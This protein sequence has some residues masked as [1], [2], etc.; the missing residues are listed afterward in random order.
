MSRANP[1]PG[2]LV[3]RR[4][5]DDPGL[6]RTVLQTLSAGRNGIDAPLRARRLVEIRLGAD[7]RNGISDASYRRA[8]AALKDAGRAAEA[9]ALETIA[10]TGAE[11]HATR[12]EWQDRYAHRPRTETEIRAM[13]WMSSGRVKIKDYEGVTGA[14]GALYHAAALMTD[15]GAVPAVVM[16]SRAGFADVVDGFAAGPAMR[17]WLQDRAL[18]IT[19]P[20]ASWATG[21]ACRAIWE[22][23]ILAWLLQNGGGSGE[24]WRPRVFTTY[25]RSEIFLAWRAVSQNAPGGGDSRLAEAELG[26]RLLRAPGWAVSEIGWPH[27]QNTVAYLRRLVVTPVTTTMAQLAA[28]QLVGQDRAALRP[29]AKPTAYRPSLAPGEVPRATAIPCVLEPPPPTALAPGPAPRI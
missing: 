17:A 23:Q 27:G 4:I 15:S 25:S 11:L 2:R 8:A 21:P 3:A 9:E 28:R 26:T 12:R 24:G 13:T 1:Q 20:L 19:G 5:L 18:G 22:E 14:D 16:T 29:G 10:A 6:A 7:P